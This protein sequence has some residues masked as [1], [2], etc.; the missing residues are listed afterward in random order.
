MVSDP[1][2]SSAEVPVP[3]TVPLCRLPS[4]ARGRVERTDLGHDDCELLRAMGLA[5]H[6]VLHVCRSGEP[7]IVRVNGTRLGLSRKM[8]RNILVAVEED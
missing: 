3:R 4:G 7:C 5:E 2:V 6:C 1:N 8:T